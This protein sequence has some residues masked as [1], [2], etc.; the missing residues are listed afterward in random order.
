MVQVQEAV[1]ATARRIAI[2]NGAWHSCDGGGKFSQ[3]VLYGKMAQGR[4]FPVPLNCIRDSLLPM[5]CGIYEKG[6]NVLYTTEDNGSQ[7][8]FCTAL[9]QILPGLTLE[10]VSLACIGHTPW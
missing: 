7:S 8:L 1:T 10:P 9:A 4:L 6:A 5:K 2:C 3:L